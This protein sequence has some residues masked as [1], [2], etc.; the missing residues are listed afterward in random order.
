M[1]G[2]GWKQ[3]RST[4]PGR[5]TAS[6]YGKWPALSFYSVRR[7]AGGLG[8]I[9]NFNWNVCRIF[10]WIMYGSFSPSILAGKD[11]AYFWFGS[12]SINQVNRSFTNKMIMNL[13]QSINPSI[14]QSIYCNQSINQ[15]IKQWS[16]CASFDLTVCTLKLKCVFCS[17]Q[18]ANIMFCNP[19]MTEHK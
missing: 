17:H 19:L 7:C 10:A 1:G 9:L 2:S 14:H 11:S 15:S 8:C 16:K 3:W 5:Q 12:D 18:L 6:L 13:H 4:S